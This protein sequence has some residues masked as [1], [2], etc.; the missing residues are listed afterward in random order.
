MI[1]QKGARKQLKIIFD[2]H[3]LE[4][5]RQFK[6]LG[7][8]LTNNGDFKQNDKYLRPKGLRA[9]YQIMRILGRSLKPSKSIKLFEKVVEPILLYN[10]EITVAFMPKKWTYECFIDN[11]WNMKLEI[12]K[13]VHNYIKQILGVGKKTSTNGILAECGKYPLCMKKYIY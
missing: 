9:S 7:N 8:I 4:E 1:F 2:K 11:I 6:Y 13:V 10:C 3:G 5:V 12:N